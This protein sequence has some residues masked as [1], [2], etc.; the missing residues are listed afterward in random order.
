MLHLPVELVIGVLKYLPLANF[1]NLMSASREWNDFFQVNQSVLYHNAAV[2]HGFTPPSIIYSELETVLSRRSLAGVHDWR[3][4]CHRQICIQKSWHGEAS[5]YV[6]SHRLAGINVHRIKTDEQRGFIIVTTS[7]GGLLVVDLHDDEVLWSLPES[8][9]RAYAHCEYGAGYLIFDRGGPLGEKEVWRLVD[10][11]NMHPGSPTFAFPDEKQQNVSSQAAESHG[12]PLEMRGHFRP[13]AVLKPPAL[14]RAFRFVYPTLLAATATSLFF[15]DIP[16]CE[17]NQVI[18][19]T[20]ISP[21]GV[22]SHEELGDTNYV[23]VSSRPD[24]HAFICGS[25]ALRAFSRTSGRCVLDLPSSQV[26]YGMNTYSFV[27]DESE[28][29]EELPGSVLKLQPTIHSVVFPPTGGRRLIDEFIAVHVS[30]CGSHL[31]ALLASSRL[32]IIPFFERVLNGEAEMRDI[33][34]DIQLGSPIS[35]AKYLAF[36]NGRVAVATGT[37]LFVVALDFESTRH[38][39]DPP[40]IS[41]H[42]AAWF[43]SPVA[44]NS[45]SCLQMTATG[46]FLN[47]APGIRETGR[48]EYRGDDL[49]PEVGFE[50]LFYLSLSEERRLTRLPNGDEVVQLFE[51][52]AAGR[53]S[54]ALFSIDFVPDISS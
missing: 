48:R 22:G 46:I 28:E 1:S 17:L 5:S 11:A 44:L 18:R 35:V 31:A 43:N 40:R 20:Q 34:I 3:S 19:D 10:D 14:T 36:E 32:V 29:Q 49:W 38:T 47:W 54:S 16:S 25:N 26:S 7:R 52:M 6:T 37:G 21:E 27:A 51:P 8:Y 39:M 30:A 53:R 50:Q 15:W 9:I 33:A 24:G 23:E 42:R 2:L 13:W 45:I 41:V 4:F 12:F